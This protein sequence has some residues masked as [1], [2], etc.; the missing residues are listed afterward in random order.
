MAHAA[1]RRGGAPGDEAG[2]RLLAAAPGLVADE[3]GGVFLGRAADFADHDDRLGG[4]VGQEHLQHVDEL[5]ALD[6]VAADADGGRLAETGIGRLEHGFIGQCAGARH[7]ADGAGREDIAR[8][9]AD[10]ALVG[11]QHA[12]TVRTD[13]ARLRAGQGLLDADHVEHR[14]AFGD[15]DDQFHLGLDGLQDRVGGEGRRHVDGGRGGARLFARFGD[16]VEY[17]QA[18]MGLAALARRNAADHLGAVG[19]G[20]LGME[21]ALAAGDALADDFGVFGD[22]N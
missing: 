6:R 1:A 22:E 4:V 12:G 3:L 11:R 5:G 21:R 15:A 13:Q 18:D 2:H 8:H 10:L 17:R 9:D 14:N 19:N 7:D 20:L 16:G